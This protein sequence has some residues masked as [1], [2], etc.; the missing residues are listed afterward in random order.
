MGL[1]LYGDPRH[2]APMIALVEVPDAVDE[3][4]VRAQLREQ[5]GVEI[6][7]AFGELQGR[8]W[9]IGTMGYNARL[10]TV[11]TLLAA[12]EHVLHEQ[13]CRVGSGTRSATDTYHGAVA[14]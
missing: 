1:A 3:A 2:K 9:R 8:V 5:H 14:A 12:L 13:G 7:A 11:L 4:A 10:D 6:M